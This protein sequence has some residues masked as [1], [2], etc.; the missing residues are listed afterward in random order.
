M[1]VSWG[2][3]TVARKKRLQEVKQLQAPNLYW[4]EKKLSTTCADTSFNNSRMGRQLLGNEI[5]E[6]CSD[7]D[8]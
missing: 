1:P 4:E 7:Y 5:P 6:L 3:L 2:D 8:G